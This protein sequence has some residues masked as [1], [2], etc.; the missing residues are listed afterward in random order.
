LVG[1]EVKLFETK[2]MMATTKTI[3]VAVAAVTTITMTK[4]FSQYS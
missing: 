3:L 2:I 4:L 1:V